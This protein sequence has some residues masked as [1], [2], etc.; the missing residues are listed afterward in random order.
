MP[1]WFIDIPSAKDPMF[2]KGFPRPAD[3]GAVDTANFKVWTPPSAQADFSNSY[4]SMQ[5]LVVELD[6]AGPK[7]RNALPGG[8]VAGSTS[9]CLANE[10][11]LWRRNQAHDV[12]FEIDDVRAAT[13]AACCWASGRWPVARPRSSGAPATWI[14]VWP[15]HAR[16]KEC[17]VSAR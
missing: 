7:I 2:A 12:P 1:F 14:A 15:S 5:R 10:G 11:E 6:P 13:P 17:G 9:P 16:E 3:H 8:T 4:G